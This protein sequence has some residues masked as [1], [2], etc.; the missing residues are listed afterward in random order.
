MEDKA[1]KRNPNWTRDE[2]ILALDY[3]LDHRNED[4]RPHSKGILHLTKK[5][6]VVSR[7]LGL[8]SA[9]VTLRNPD[10]VEMKLRN[11]SAHDP[12]YTENGRTSL[13]RGNK[14][15]AILWNEF[16]DRPSELKRTASSIIALS[17]S[18][19]TTSTA[20]NEDEFDAP[21]GR[22][23][24]RIHLY[25]ERNRTLV[26]RKKA[27]VLRDA[28]RICCEICGFD[29]LETYGER[30]R[31]FIECH[32]TAP[33][34]SLGENARTSLKDL[35]L[36]CSNCHR[37]IHAGRPWWSLEEAKAVVAARSLPL[38]Y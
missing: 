12:L 18:T 1:G 6:A 19:E 21:E 3:Y 14:L 13:N 23:L 5:I 27:S 20:E 9:G 33:I 2:L 36:V 8:A 24:T 11:L 17:G 10:A 35:A 38:G 31:N 4:P 28:G 7:A 29:F 16:S 34:S 32:H 22:L 37:M 15:E 25:R 26:K 30:G